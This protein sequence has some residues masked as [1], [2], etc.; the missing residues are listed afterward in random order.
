MIVYFSRSRSIAKEL[1]LK[2]GVYILYDTASP[3]QQTIV[4]FY[5]SSEVLDF[6]LWIC[7][8]FVLIAHKK[9]DLCWNLNLAWRNIFCF[10][11]GLSWFSFFAIETFSSLLHYCGLDNTNSVLTLGDV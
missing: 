10:S 8:I 1:F 9:N 11:W 6:M 7:H 2:E 3:V 5:N 4:A